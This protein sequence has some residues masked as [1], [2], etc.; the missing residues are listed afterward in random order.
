[1]Q[2]TLDFL[3]ASGPGDR[4]LARIRKNKQ[5]A[6]SRQ[7]M[8]TKADVSELAVV[9]QVENKTWPKN[10][11]PTSEMSDQQAHNGPGSSD[12]LEG[13]NKG[14]GCIP[15][16]TTGVP[17]GSSFAVVLD[18]AQT[19]H[20]KVLRMLDD[21]LEFAQR[22]MDDTHSGVE[23][24]QAQAAQREACSEA[25][26][27]LRRDLADYMDSATAILSSDEVDILEDEMWR[28]NYEQDVVVCDALLTSWLDYR[29]T[30]RV[31]DGETADD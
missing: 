21:I 30:G 6:M 12:E 7:D 17:V 20:Q 19:Q 16:G 4:R 29:I 24:L 23:L 5:R 18:A 25:F 2:P 10:K 8:H 11:T 26:W 15:L 31:D 3:E 28:L 13:A 9:C 22:H 14:A 27:N 1:M